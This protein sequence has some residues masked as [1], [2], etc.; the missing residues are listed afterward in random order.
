MPTTNR[1]FFSN[2]LAAFRAH[3]A[4]Q[5]TASTT[6]PSAASTT[7]S[8]ASASTLA[9]TPTSAPAATTSTNAPSNPRAIATKAGTP[10]TGATTVAIQTTGQFQP[11]RQH[12]ASPYSRSPGSPGSPGF[13]TPLGGSATRQRRGSD[14]SSEGFRDAGGPEKWYIGGRTATG[15]ERFYKLGVVKRPRSIDRL[16]VDRLSL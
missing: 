16:S 14:S 4:I 5:K 13:N 12:S 11:T 9:P 10:S 15:E 3:S 2:F 1:P 7:A 8:T 6:V